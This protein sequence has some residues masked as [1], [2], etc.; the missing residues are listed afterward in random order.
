YLPL[1][2]QI[3]KGAKEQ[4]KGKMMRMHWPSYQYN[5]GSYVCYTKGQFTGIGGAEQLP[6]GNL[7]FAGEHC[8]GD[9]AGFM[10]GA[11]MSGREAAEGILRLLD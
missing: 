7:F 1:W 5:L 8:G 3:L 11:A 2:D 6:L 4:F 10:N 9:F